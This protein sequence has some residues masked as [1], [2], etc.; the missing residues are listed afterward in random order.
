MMPPPTLKV[1]QQGATR[2][3]LLVADDNPDNRTIFATILQHLGFRTAVASGGFA[4]VEIAQRERPDLI[5]MDLMMP[6]LG[7]E[8]ALR[9]IRA[10]PELEHVP[11]LAVTAQVLYTT[12]SSKADGFCGLL[13]KPVSPR[14]LADAVQRCLAS[15]DAGLRWTDLPSY[16]QGVQPVS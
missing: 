15:A 4:S 7:G 2:P 14:N 6:D 8:E 3:L 9:R 10:N 13:H 1:E 12:A 5:I 16:E 11:V